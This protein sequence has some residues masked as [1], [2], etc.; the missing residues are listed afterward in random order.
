MDTPAAPCYSILYKSASYNFFRLPHTLSPVDSNCEVNPAQHIKI[1]ST[2]VI[3]ATGLQYLFKYINKYLSSVFLKERV[4][5]PV[6]KN[7]RP[8]KLVDIFIEK[9]TLNH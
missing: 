4:D 8:E 2:S 1:E 6:C 3:A 9:I 7:I 5:S